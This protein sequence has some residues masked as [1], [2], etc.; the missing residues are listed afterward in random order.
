MTALKELGLGLNKLG[1]EGEKLIKSV[2]SGDVD[3]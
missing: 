2:F 1:A 3:F